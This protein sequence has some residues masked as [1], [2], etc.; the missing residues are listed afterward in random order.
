MIATARNMTLA[1]L[2]CFATGIAAAA[3]G[4]VTYFDVARG[5]GKALLRALPGCLGARHVNVLRPFRNLRQHSHPVRQHLYEAAGD[6]QEM[7]LRSSP[8]PELAHFQRGQQR[9]VPGQHAKVAFVSW[10][11]HF[12]DLFAHQCA[13]GRDDFQGQLGR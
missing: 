2:A 4:P 5:S 1:L 9:R 6:R 10:Q 3:Q 7:L 8:V 13:V 12:V 11:L